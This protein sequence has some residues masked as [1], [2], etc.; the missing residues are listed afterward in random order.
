MDM[1]KILTA[2]AT[3]AIMLAASLSLGAKVKMAPIFSDNMVLQQK[4]EAPV[5]GF[6][7]P[8][9]KITVKVSWDRKG[10]YETVA[11]KDGKWTVKV[12]TLK[13][14]GP[15][16][17]VI[18]DGEETRLD[19]I[20]FGEVW[21]CSGQSN[22]EMPLA[23]WGRV[24]DYENEIRNA[25]YPEIR[26]FQATHTIATAPQEGVLPNDFGG[27]VECS[28]E[29]VPEFS[30]TA[31]FFGR[32]LHLREHVP[33]GLIHSSWGGTFIEA[34]MRSGAFEGI[35]YI[36]DQIAKLADYGN[37]AATRQSEYGRQF[38]IWS[39]KLRE[40]EGF[41]NGEA[42][43][44]GT[45]FNDGAWTSMDLPAQM[46]DML[47]GFNGLAW[48]RKTVEIPQ[49]WEG[50]G[51]TL[52]LPA[53]DDYDFTFFNGMQI[54]EGKGWNTKRTYTVPA[55]EVKAGKATVTVFV[56]D[57]GGTGG[58]VGDAA[59]LKIG[60]SESESMTLAG[61]W[62]FRE[63][64]KL[65]EV[66]PAPVDLS[67]SPNYPTVLYNA[68]ISPIV[69]Y[70][71]K[72]AIWYQG[73]N[74]VGGADMYAELLPLMISDWRSLWGEDFPFYIVQLANY[75][76]PQAG[77]VN[78]SAWA[79][80][81][82][83]QEKTSR[84]VENTGLAVLIDVGEAYDIHP[85]NKQ[86]VGRRLALQALHKTY[87]HGNLVCDGPV[88]EGYEIEGHAI[89]LKFSSCGKGLRFKDGKPAGFVIAGADHNFHWADAVIDGD[90]VVVS[91]PE[92][93]MPLAARYAWADN[94]VISLYNSEG[95]PASPFR[96]DCWK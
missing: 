89:R 54:G 38:G 27:W 8:G 56:I 66:A 58:I 10:K 50:R 41:E 29:T 62:K 80:L 43:Y 40:T 61:A 70:S 4:C 20:L 84:C 39:G 93:R 94:P 68:M 95:L 3:A 11:G 87:G 74:N 36:E 49:E 76:E 77:P 19:N 59:E 5:F 86:E 26:L 90:T 71:I 52:T 32:E 57:T 67:A 96:T 83:A 51:L 25:S 45:G 17:I 12:R 82:E 22:M 2:S 42:V 85:K 16:S 72:G 79:E 47:P 7:E 55:A 65:S 28:P 46:Q 13:A 75:L 64:L 1:K 78:R 73:C 9:K 21:L 91:S 14:G 88:F 31:Y 63:T 44:A 81:R 35:R 34:W 33:V 6:A 60:P 30:A 15:H 23:G 48:F 92:V 69:P 18:S 37:D 24:K 53:V